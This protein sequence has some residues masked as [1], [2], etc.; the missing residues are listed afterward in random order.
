VN[1]IIK[2]FKGLS[3]S[4][5]FR[6]VLLGDFHIG[7]V[8]CDE[9]L[10][11]EHIRYIKETPDTYW[12]DMGDK[13]EAITRLDKRWDSGSF[14]SWIKLKDVDDLP[15][16]QAERYIQLVK[17]IANK[18]LGL[19][20]GNHE[21]TLKRAYSQDIH[22]YICLKLRVKN[23]GFLCFYRLRFLRKK[24]SGSQH[25]DMVLA[26]GAGG[27]RYVG[28]KI[29]K[30][31][32]MANDFEADIYAV[33]HHHDKISYKKKRLAFNNSGKIVEKTIIL[34]AVPSFFKTYV[35]N[36]S[37]YSERALY[38]PTST[39]VIKITIQPFVRKNTNDYD[40]K[41]PSWQLLSPDIHI[42]D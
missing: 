8:G 13:I 24:D 40:K 9:R 25:I 22:D 14:A 32:A 20:E 2:E 19:I 10:I 39:G 21:S 36:F 38:P 26:H 28:S 31:N 6:V 4:Q 17:P 29:N 30:L 11:K 7:N 42:S 37:T 1:L 33:G 34:T 23:L 15:K 41:Y 35:E 3:I 5:R 27:G 18:C 16:V 12:I